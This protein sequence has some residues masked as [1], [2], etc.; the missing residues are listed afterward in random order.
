MTCEVPDSPIAD[1]APAPQG[2]RTALAFIAVFAV[3]VIS[4]LAAYRFAIDTVAND[5]YL[6][7]VSRHT[8]WLLSLVGHEAVLEKNR[9]EGSSPWKTWRARAVRQRDRGENGP[10]I[11]FVLKPGLQHLLDEQER[12]LAQLRTS[13][14]DPRRIADAEAE[15]AALRGRMS[16]SLSDPASR[17][18]RLGLTFT[19]I[20]VPACG[21]IEVMVIFLAAV[22]AFPATWHHRLRGLAMGLPLMYLVN[23]ARLACLACLGALDESGRWFNFVHEYVWQS[24]YVIFV[25]LVWM[26]WVE[27]GKRQAA[28]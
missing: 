22:V 19:F 20:V 17:R 2:R 24:V 11:T 28:R 7:E 4:L 12:S 5:R 1:G 26:A 15:V 10:Q 9:P 25:V 14:A 3:C 23:I 13:Q 27:L 16:G 8:G 6:Y 21:A 18:E